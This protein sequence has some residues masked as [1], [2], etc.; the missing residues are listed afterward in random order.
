[1][2]NLEV[3]TPVIE[4]QAV[5]KSYGSGD[6]A[7]NVLKGVNL[8][9]FPGQIASIK[10]AS[11]S[12][13]STLLNILAGLDTADSGDVIWAGE[14]INPQKF[15]KHA[16]AKKRGAFCG[17]VF[18]SYYLVPEL[19]ALENVL[20]AKRLLGPA[21]ASDQ[22]RAEELLVK[23]GVD[24]RKN[25]LPNQL[26][27]GERQ[28]VAIARA[29]INQPKLIIA[30]EPTGNLDER[31]GEEVISLL[32]NIC[33]ELDTACLLVTHSVGYAKRADTQKTLSLGLLEAEDS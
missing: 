1:M 15:N 9:V 4:A 6:S 8:Q 7:L 3:D 29:L 32:L 2:S 12:G 19:N 18:Q 27:G 17:F 13:K 28:R 16:L 30:D 10:G 14:S 11:G 31:T 26:S 21:K 20:L 25:G 22:K 5:T 23:L 24:H 33:R